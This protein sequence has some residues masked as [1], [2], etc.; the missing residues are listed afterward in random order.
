VLCTYDT[1]FFIR[2]A[3][4]G[5]KRV[6]DSSHYTKFLNKEIKKLREKKDKKER[7]SL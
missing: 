3:V 4:L 1:I 6:G 7:K 5:S 2:F